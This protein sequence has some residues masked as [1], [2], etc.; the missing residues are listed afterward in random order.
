MMDRLAYQM[1]SDKSFDA[2]VSNL[3]KQTSE[4]K[5]RV[6]HVHDVQAT[7][8]EKGLRRG[9]LK[10]IEVCNAGFAHEA[11]GKNINVALFMPCKF[12][13]YTEG[14]QTVVTLARPS[15]I[16]DMMPGTGLDELAGNVEET[17]K[18]VMAASV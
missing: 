12:S 7:L 11:L 6:L 8:A 17:L 3:E 10:I 18:K 9:P 16:A 4:H 14:D 2:V 15:M 5:F 1:K 13:V